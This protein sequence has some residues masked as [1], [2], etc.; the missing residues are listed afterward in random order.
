MKKLLLAFLATGVLALA[1]AAAVVRLGL[2]D[3]SATGP[4]LAP[5]YRLLETAMHHSVKRR[6]ADIRA[7]AL[8]GP[9]RLALG[10]ACYQAHCEQ[11]HGAPGVA[12]GALGQGMQ[13][14][15]GP[16]IDAARRWQPREVY[17]ITRHGIKMSGMPAWELR[18]S[19]DELWA[20]AA[21]VDQLASLSPAAYARAVA[22]SGA[23]ACRSTAADCPPGDDC[24]TATAAGL[25]PAQPRPRHEPARLALRQYACIACHEV[26]GVVGPQTQ[27]GPPLAHFARRERLPGG[28]PNTHDNL[29]RWIREP[30][31]MRPATAM[32]DMGVTEA[33]ARLMADYLLKLE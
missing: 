26:P 11:C 20:V 31:G 29:V 12:Q 7:P 2:Y 32:P 14:L 30:A 17:W 28:L 3:V 16:L 8:E 10:A 18:L 23:A 24:S 27:V 5:V 22:G 13:P 9:G 19:E 21:F 25:E 6:S 15:P 1:A 4:H 33:H